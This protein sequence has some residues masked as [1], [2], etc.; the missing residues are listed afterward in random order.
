MQQPAAVLAGEQPTIDQHAEQLLD[1][2][3]IALGPLDDKFAE[4][5]RQTA[6]EQLIKHPHAIA[7]GERLQLEQ[8]TA[9]ASAP[10]RSA[11]EKLGPR[12][13]D[14]K[15]RP[16]SP[17]EHVLEQVQKLAL[18]PMNVLD[19]QN[20]RS[21]RDEIGQEVGPGILEKIA[22]GKRVQITGDVET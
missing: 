8:L 22:S 21:L 6:R 4:R 20:R 12:R 1:E 7:R 2:E 3:G 17:A 18:R 16:F 14:H 9:G 10:T 13:H 19:Q 15:Q 5:R 11:F